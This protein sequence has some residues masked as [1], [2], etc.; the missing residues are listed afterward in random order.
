MFDYMA[1]SPINFMI[2]LVPIGILAYGIYDLLLKKNGNARKYVFSMYVFAWLFAASYPMCDEQHFFAGLIP[3]LPLGFVFM[4][5]KERHKE[6]LFYGGLLV[7]T[8]M[9][10]LNIIIAPDLE[11]YPLSEINRYEGIPMSKDISRNIETVCTYIEDAET[12]GNKVYIAYEYAAMYHIPL[13]KYVKNWDLL[14][15]GNLGT[16]SVEEM[17]DVEAES[18]FLVPKKGVQLNKMAH[19]ELMEYIRKNYICID[20]VEQFEV[21]RKMEV[22]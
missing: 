11:D 17:L 14:L 20:E 9:T 15:V 21:Y 6:I 1:L 3:V 10:M 13:D 5:D 7:G 8:F 2:G 4:I 12:K 18:I 16:V 19:V 22:E